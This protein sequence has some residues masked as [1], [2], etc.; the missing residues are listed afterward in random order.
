M[1]EC[2]KKELTD[3]ELVCNIITAFYMHEPN[4]Q[5]TV[6]EIHQHVSSHR[7]VDEERV[8]ATL[9]AMASQALISHGWT[10]TVEN[11]NQREYYE[12]SIVRLPEG[13]YGHYTYIKP[14]VNSNATSS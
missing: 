4:V 1:P 11:P 13:G 9:K 8:A 12:W 6:K 3:I 7:M 5:L 10:G 14:S 2:V